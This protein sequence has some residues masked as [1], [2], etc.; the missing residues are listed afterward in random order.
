MFLHIP[1]IYLK[2]HM[3]TWKINIDIFTAMR[4]SKLT[5]M[6]LYKHLYSNCQMSCELSVRGERRTGE[7]AV[8]SST[9]FP[10]N[11]LFRY[12]HASSFAWYQDLTSRVVVIMEG[13]ACQGRYNRDINSKDQ[14]IFRMVHPQQS[15]FL[16]RLPQH[17]AAPNLYLTVPNPVQPG[18]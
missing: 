9:Y 12:L 4:I 14:E 17:Q 3:T 1:D 8:C 2:V 13:V 18:N 16:R 7:R 5:K 10:I 15:V 6:Y 11:N